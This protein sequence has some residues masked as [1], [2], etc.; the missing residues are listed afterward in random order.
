MALVE[1]VIG[2]GIASS[3]S[4]YAI[5]LVAGVAISC[6]VWRF[7]I[8]GIVLM[9]LLAAGPDTPYNLTFRL[10]GRTTY[11]YEVV[12]VIL[13]A[14]AAYR[15]KRDTWGGATGGILLAFLL[16]LGV[17]TAF[18][19]L[20]GREA[21]NDGLNYGRPFFALSI[22]WVIIRL[23]PDRRRLGV[24][25][26]AA[27]VLAALSGAI[28]LWL[29]LSGNT[30][31]IFQGA[32]GTLQ[33]PSSIGSLLRVRMPG[34][35]LGF[36][37]LWLVV[38]WLIRGRRP[39]WVWVLC[40]PLI[41]VDILVSQ[42]RNMWVIAGLSLILVILIAGPH[43]RARI[44]ASLA[45][46]GAVVAIL[47]AAPLGGSGA[48]SPIN[49]IVDRAASIL[50]PSAIR[51][52]SSASD[53][54]Y[55]DREGWKSAI[56]HLAIGIGPGANY[57]AELITTSGGTHG[58]TPRLFLQNQYLYILVTTGIPGI[59][60]WML[61][62]L[63]TLRNALMRGAPI[64]SRVLGVG[65]LGLSLTGIVMLSLTDPSYLIALGLV[66]GAIFA[67]R[68][69]SR[70]PAGVRVPYSVAEVR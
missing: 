39:R 58:V 23:A 11:A 3:H 43:V 9:L 69:A 32:G 6:L 25:L 67:L 40:L 12:L 26:T 27:I 36:M 61:F 41:V 52:S 37:L 34:L 59:T 21:L 16:I 17:S 55:E 14:R 50:N 31:T 2:V 53:R 22:F 48:S 45:A 70:G 56:H 29:A 8:P 35:G 49:P 7:P 24:I 10:A 18:G 19:I 60:A 63:A 47:V 38:L 57:G 33:I 28:G 66:A 68:P 15:P 46:L 1:V 4:K 64:E 42:N 65:V 44:F 20:A 13:L 5:E 51:S 62:L 54:D 30:N